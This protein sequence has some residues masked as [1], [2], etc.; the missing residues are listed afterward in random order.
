MRPATQKNKYGKQ[1]AARIAAFACLLCFAVPMLLSGAFLL[2]YS[3]HHHAPYQMSHDKCDHNQG[4]AT[5][6][7]SAPGHGND[8]ADGNCLLCAL[9]HN[10]ANLLKTLGTAFAGTP[11][12]LTIL[13]AAITLLFI[14]AYYFRS[15][16][17]LKIRINC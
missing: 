3:D 14:K 6:P 16:I 5:V 9:L 17:E 1:T 10:A 13:F 12:M 2:S 15:P 8:G 7:V 11:L 4:S